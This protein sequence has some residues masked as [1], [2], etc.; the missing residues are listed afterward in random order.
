MTK[1]RGEDRAAPRGAAPLWRALRHSSS[2]ARANSLVFRGSLARHGRCS[3]GRHGRRVGARR[4]VAHHVDDGSFLGRSWQRGVA[5]AGDGGGRG[6]HVVRGGR[7][8]LVAH[9]ARRGDGPAPPRQRAGEAG[10]GRRDPPPLARPLGPHPG[11][12]LLRAAL[13]ARDARP[14]RLRR[15]RDPHPRRPPPPDE[16]AHLPR[17]PQRAPR[18]AELPGGAR[19]PALR[20][21]RGRG[22]G[23]EG[24][25]PRPGVCVPGR[26]PRALRG[27]RHRHRALP[28]RRPAPRG[29][30]PQRRRAHLRRAVP[31]HGVLRRG[32]DEP[33]R[34]GPLHLGGRRRAR[35]RGGR[36]QAGPL[37]PR[38]LPHRRRRRGHRGHRAGAFRRHRRRPRGD[39]D[40]GRR[41]RGGHGPAAATR[42]A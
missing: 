42:A 2:A 26:A 19:P 16:R 18:V 40:R 35:P 27:V 11:P 9:R 15:Q 5:G 30:R 25:P 14:R 33:R 38:P 12:P 23:R 17:R 22:H 8:G 4:S 28:L 39:G 34:L 29:A 6:Q 32:R 24:Q 36:R 20:R 31:P 37:P 13:L 41:R 10:R 7:R 1:L 21:G 3:M